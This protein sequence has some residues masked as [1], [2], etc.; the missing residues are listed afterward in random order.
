MYRQEPGSK[1]DNEVTE[2]MNRWVAKKPTSGSWKVYTRVRKDDR[3]V[4]HM[5]LH[6]LW[7]SE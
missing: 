4:Y 7:T 3:K 1:D 2:Q 5:R 6:R